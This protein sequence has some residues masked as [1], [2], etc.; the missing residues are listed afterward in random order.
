MDQRKPQATRLTLT[1]TPRIPGSMC[2]ALYDWWLVDGNEIAS[3]E[4][5]LLLLQPADDIQEQRTAIRRLRPHGEQ[6]LAG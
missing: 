1:G 5:D 4:S 6:L 3:A 2:R